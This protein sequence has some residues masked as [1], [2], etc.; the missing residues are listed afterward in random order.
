M[1]FRL[2][3]AISIAHLATSMA[4]VSIVSPFV[5]VVVA[6]TAADPPCASNVTVETGF[7]AHFAYSVCVLRVLAGV[8]EEFQGQVS[9]YDSGFPARAVE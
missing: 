7:T 1:I 4:F 8:E 2:P 6:G 9:E 5:T 3:A